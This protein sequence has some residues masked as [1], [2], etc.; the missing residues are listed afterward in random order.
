[1][2]TA[3]AVSGAV[4]G[5]FAG[6]VYTKVRGDRMAPWIL[7]RAT[8]VVGYLLLVMLVLVG[9]TLS[10][11]R[12]AAGG[13]SAPA[14][15]RVHVTLAVLTLAALVLHVVILATD[16]YAGVGWAGTFLP[17]QASDRPVAV[18][19]GVLGTWV[20]ILSGISAALAGRLALRLWFPLH[21]I[22]G[23]SFVLVLLH[24]LLAGSDSRA[25][26]SMYVISGGLVLAVAGHRYLAR[27]RRR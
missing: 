8:G 3:L 10:H 25:L 13:R 24:G 19:L 5:A 2:G 6:L 21:R 1:M 17:M 11:P 23:V 4:T 12:R 16:R 20:G 22:A 7:G 27:G 9:L 14:R 15:M 26:L 18:T